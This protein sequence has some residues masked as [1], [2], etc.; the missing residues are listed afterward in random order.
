MYQ[1]DLRGHAALVY[2]SSVHQRFRI[3]E[4]IAK[5]KAYHAEIHE[6]IDWKAELIKKFD[7]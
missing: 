3:E 4:L 2:E 6:F 7:A 1:E 5:N